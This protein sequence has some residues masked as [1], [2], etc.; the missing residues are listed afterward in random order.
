MGGGGGGLEKK[1]IRTGVGN[2]K[3]ISRTEHKGH[4]FNKLSRCPLDDASYKIPRL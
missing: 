4:N 2:Q 1:I 3:K